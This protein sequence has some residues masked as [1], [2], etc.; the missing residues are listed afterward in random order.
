[1]RGFSLLEVM[2]AMA[3][4]SVFAVAY[5]AADGS[6]VDRSIR[7]RREAK[8]LSLTQSKINEII[9]SPPKFEKSLALSPDTGN[10]ADDENYSY[11]VEWKQFALPDLGKI[12]GGEEGGDPIQQKIF[13]VMK[14]NMEKLVW[15][16]EV[17]VTDKTTDEKY[18]LSTWLYDDKGKVELKGF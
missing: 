5:I 12:Q 3:I 10:L 13:T 2:I 8:L 4:F 1:M 15:Q 6:S 14:E 7:M 18:T 11:T 9:T 16:V 17:T